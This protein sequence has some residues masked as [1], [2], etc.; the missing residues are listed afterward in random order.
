LQSSRNHFAGCCQRLAGS[1]CFLAVGLAVVGVGVAAAAVVE[2]RA[3]VVWEGIVAVA[4]EGFDHFE[5]QEHHTGETVVAVPALKSK[6][7]K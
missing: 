5:D 7:D 3:A 2:G 6:E 1:G 4:V